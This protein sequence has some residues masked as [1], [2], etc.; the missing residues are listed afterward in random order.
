[1][2]PIKYYKTFCNKGSPAC[3]NVRTGLLGFFFLNSARINK[4]GAAV[5]AIKG[6]RMGQREEMVVILASFAKKKKKDKKQ[7]DGHLFEV[8]LK[9]VLAAASCKQTNK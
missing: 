1:M 3:V 7:K 4:Q 2:V 9:C 8:Q 6:T 5:V